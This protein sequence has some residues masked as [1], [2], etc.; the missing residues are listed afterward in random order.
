MQVFVLYFY[1]WKS[2]LETDRCLIIIIIVIKL[3]AIL[4]KEIE[5]R[6]KLQ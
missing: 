3:K 5:S 2:I 6:E 1:T 4:V